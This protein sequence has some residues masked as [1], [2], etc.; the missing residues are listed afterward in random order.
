MSINGDISFFCRTFDVMSPRHC[1][2][3]EKKIEMIMG[4]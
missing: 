2:E 3:N 1:D 4:G